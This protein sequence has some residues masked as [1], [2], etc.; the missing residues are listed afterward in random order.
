METEAPYIDLIEPDTDL[1]PISA[2]SETLPELVE[3]T[4]MPTIELEKEVGILKEYGNLE[5][6]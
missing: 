2:V 3:R 4:Y 5:A 6:S 1:D